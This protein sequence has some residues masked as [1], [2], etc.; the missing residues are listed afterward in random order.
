MTAG[1]GVLRDE[2]SLDLAEAELSAVADLAPSGCGGPVAVADHEVAN[3]IE[4]GAALVEAARW[5]R[6][7]RGAHTR[8]DFPGS[9]GAYRRRFVL[10]GGAGR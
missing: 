7:T 8:R 2:G 9:D 6:E 1:A 3:L 5:R 10:E 4:V